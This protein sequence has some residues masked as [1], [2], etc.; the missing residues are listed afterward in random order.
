[1]ALANSMQRASPRKNATPE[2]KLE[3]CK[4]AGSQ[5][6]SQG[7]KKL[8]SLC[9]KAN[10]GAPE[11]AAG[12]QGEMEANGGAPEKANGGAPDKANG[13]AP[14][15]LAETK[16]PAKDDGCAP[17]LAGRTCSVRML[18]AKVMAARQSLQADRAEARVTPAC[19]RT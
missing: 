8:E 7:L 10:G 3:F 18:A 12:A 13:G 19:T 16:I 1:M 2:I 4:P 14:E 5:A 6:G 15:S 17:K 11:R 9:D